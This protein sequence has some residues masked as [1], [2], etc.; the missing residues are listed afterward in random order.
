MMDLL[1]RIKDRLPTAT[2][3]ALG[4]EQW[5]GAPEQFGGIYV[6]NDSGNGAIFVKLRQPRHFVCHFS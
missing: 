3:N 5:R 6:K 1:R 4:G 2:N